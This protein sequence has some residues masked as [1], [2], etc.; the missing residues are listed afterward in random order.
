MI[1]I[2]K[3]LNDAQRRQI[4]AMSIDGEAGQNDYA[5]ELGR[6]GQ[7]VISRQRLTLRAVANVFLT[8]EQYNAVED[9]T[10][11]TG[12][13]EVVAT[14]QIAKI[15]DA[16]PT[17]IMKRIRLYYSAWHEVEY[18]L[19]HTQHEPYSSCLDFCAIMLCKAIDHTHPIGFSIGDY[20][21]RILDRIIATAR[22]NSPS[23]FDMPIG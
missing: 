16:Q 15:I 23:D 1:T 9:V 3:L 6:D 19:D 18:A 21:D 11:L 17:E 22:L 8:V 2:Y 7:T 10:P 4:A 14:F 12:F 5:Y 20:Y 13:D